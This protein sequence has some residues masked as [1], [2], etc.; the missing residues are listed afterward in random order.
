MSEPNHESN[1]R[2]EE[3]TLKDLLSKFD[4]YWSLLWERKF[5]IIGIGLVLGTIL[6]IKTFYKPV[7]YTARLTFMLNA[8]EGNNL[9]GAAAILGQFGFGG[10]AT[11]EFNLDKIIALSS[12][13][14]IIHT[15]LFEKISLENQ[16][17][18][19]INHLINEYSLMSE[20][21]DNRF[22]TES[23]FNG[24]T[25]ENFSRYEKEILKIIYDKVVG[26]PKKGR[27]GVLNTVVN[28]KTGIL[29]IE[30][31]TEEEE[32]SIELCKVIYEKLSEFY[33][34]KSTEKQRLTVENLKNS[35]DSIRNELYRLEY[36]LA[37]FQDGNK[38]VKL[39]KDLLM[40]QKISREVQLLTILLGEIKKNLSTSE[41]LLKNATPF[42]QEID[43]PIS[44]LKKTS[45]SYIKIFIKGFS[46]GVV[47]VSFFIL[48]YLSFNR[49]KN[50]F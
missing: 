25:I 4:E 9:G 49:I 37:Q 36:Q 15:V 6:V 28:D 45:K 35:E 38:K 17:D 11:S 31:I 22:L 44:P 14:R 23:F 1:T 13:Q 42:F 2:N 29:S 10:G 34:N 19:V 47:I 7:K 20:L 48:F 5:L 30:I 50:R 27:K 18:Y 21:K 3:I 8:E 39:N 41:F 46:F 43:T 40:Q 32:L 26:D 16:V 33:V 24:D 12:S